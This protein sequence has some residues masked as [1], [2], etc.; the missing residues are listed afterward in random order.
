MQAKD[1]ANQIFSRKAS[2]AAIGIVALCYI[3]TISSGQV[4]IDQPGVSV[5]PAGPAAPDAAAEIDWRIPAMITLI[6]CLAVIVQGLLDYLRPRD[7]KIINVDLS[8]IKPPGTENL[9]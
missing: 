8:K 5:I 7:K 3:A 1:L 2:I 9:N 4:S 6:T